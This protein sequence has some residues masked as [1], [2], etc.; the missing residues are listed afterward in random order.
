[1]HRL[2]HLPYIEGSGEDVIE[3]TLSAKHYDNQKAKVGAVADT[4]PQWPVSSLDGAVC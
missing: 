4:A 3:V 2:L 1:M